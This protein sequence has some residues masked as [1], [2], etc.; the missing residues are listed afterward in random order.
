MIVIVCTSDVSDFFWESLGLVV[1]N[2]DL[3]G[4]FEYFIISRWLS[5]YKNTIQYNTIQYNTIQYNTIQYKTI[6][7]NTIQYNI[8]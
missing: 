7:Y 8:I 6:Q 4:Y 1:S 3:D 2:L 5:I